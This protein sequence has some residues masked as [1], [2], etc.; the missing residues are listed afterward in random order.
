MD[1]P[2]TPPLLFTIPFRFP[3]T[4]QPLPIPLQPPPNKP[5]IHLILTPH[6]HISTHPTTH[7]LWFLLLTLLLT[8][9]V[10]FT[11]SI[12]FNFQNTTPPFHYLYETLHSLTTP[13]EP[14]H[15]TLVI[16]NRLTSTH[17]HSSFALSSTFP[18]LSI[19]VSREP[20]TMVMYGQQRTHT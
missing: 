15:D 16:L 6:S 7:T 14:D 9:F 3:T 10:L 11:L 8:N 20:A 5:T 4:T 1:I 13:P 17:W 19:D 2:T 18:T 12:K